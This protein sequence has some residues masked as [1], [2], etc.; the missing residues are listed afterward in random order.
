M[1]RVTGVESDE[2]L[3]RLTFDLKAQIA[4]PYSYQIVVKYEELTGRFI[5][6][7]AKLEQGISIVSDAFLEV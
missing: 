4:S 1:L 6:T 7:A 5:V 3:N 2:N